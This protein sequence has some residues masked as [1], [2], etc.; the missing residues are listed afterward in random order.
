MITE[1][2][3][4]PHCWVCGR[5]FN[6]VEPPG[7]AQRE[8]H[9]VVPQAYG[10]TDG[11]TVSLCDGHHTAIHKIAIA[12]KQKKPHH[13]FLGTYDREQIAKLEYLAQVIFNAEQVTRDD[14]NK[15]LQ[16]VLSLDSEMKTMLEAL[17]R[18]YPGARSRAALIRTAIRE[19]YLRHYRS[20]RS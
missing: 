11:P 15:R 5:R 10:G 13:Q 20:L 1:T 16:V 9:H 17:G 3:T 18:V 7:P 8:E 6:D 14:P 4:L 2:I 19:L 12:W